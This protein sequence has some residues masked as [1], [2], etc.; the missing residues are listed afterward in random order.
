[1]FQ[2]YLIEATGGISLRNWLALHKAPKRGKQNDI[3]SPESEISFK[4]GEMGI[5]DLK[6]KY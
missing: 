6:M 3:Q 2:W 5:W 1:M 4:A